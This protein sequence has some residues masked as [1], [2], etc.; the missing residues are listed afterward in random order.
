MTV[1]DAADAMDAAARSI[2]LLRDAVGQAGAGTPDW[3]RVLRQA[4]TATRV[5][6]LDG[7]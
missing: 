7:A 3:E 4:R 5:V 6:A 1:P 2:R